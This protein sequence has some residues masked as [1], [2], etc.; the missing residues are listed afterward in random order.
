MRYCNFSPCLH[1]ELI[2][3]RS[4][5]NSSLHSFQVCLKGRN[6]AKQ[7]LRNCNE[8]R[9]SSFSIDEKSFL[10]M[11][12]FSPFLKSTCAFF[13][14]SIPSIFL[15]E[16]PRLRSTEFFYLFAPSNASL[17]TSVAFSLSFLFF[18]FGSDDAQ[19]LFS[20]R[21][22]PGGNGDKLL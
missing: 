19:H 21:Q 16:V 18:F 7:F 9:Q 1:T 12:T 15:T 2:Q 22:K 14:L 6:C 17:F 11:Q 20:R 3:Q 8:T 5:K 10:R 4:D 13:P